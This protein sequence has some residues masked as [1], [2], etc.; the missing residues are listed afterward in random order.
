[1]KEIPQKLGEVW[2][3]A[4]TSA[5]LY[6]R[7]TALG[8]T[9]SP[10]CHTYTLAIADQQLEAQMHPL[11][12][13]WFFTLYVRNQE[14]FSM[15]KAV[16][17]SFPEENCW[18]TVGPKPQVTSSNMHPFPFL[19]AGIEANGETIALT[20]RAARGRGEAADQGIQLHSD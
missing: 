5:H 2:I 3:N 12:L 17:L 16:T 15:H 13:V 6:A 8:T 18:F 1:M 20:S 14:L 4:G 11:K 9:A 7:H 10:L 19:L